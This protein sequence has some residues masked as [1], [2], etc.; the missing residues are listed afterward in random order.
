MGW[1]RMDLMRDRRDPLVGIGWDE[2]HVSRDGSTTWD[3]MG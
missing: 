1:D 2:M 3:R